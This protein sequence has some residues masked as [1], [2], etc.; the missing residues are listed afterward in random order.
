[1]NHYSVLVCVPASTPLE[2]R[3]SHL[4]DIMA[5]AG[6]ADKKRSNFEPLWHDLFRQ[7]DRTMFGLSR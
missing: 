1:M 5:P 4:E 2:R 3:K 7:D 6:M